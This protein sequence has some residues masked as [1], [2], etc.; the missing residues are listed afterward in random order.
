MVLADIQTFPWG[1]TNGVWERKDNERMKEKKRKE[2]ERLNERVKKMKKKKIYI[3]VK[4]N[5]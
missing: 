4:L 1:F 2:N 5:I 3:N